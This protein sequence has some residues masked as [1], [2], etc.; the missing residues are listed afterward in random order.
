MLRP[1]PAFERIFFSAL[2]N[3]SAEFIED[4]RK[5][6]EHKKIL[7]KV[8]MDCRCSI[9][10][11]SVAYVFVIEIRSADETDKTLQTDKIA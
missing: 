1:F 11:G 9:Q 10:P 6:Q 2:L 5:R 7:S 4:G 8:G 3:H